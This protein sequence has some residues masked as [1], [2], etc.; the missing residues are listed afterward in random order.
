M[1][2]VPTLFFLN[3]KLSFVVKLFG[4]IEV[5]IIRPSLDPSSCFILI[6]DET[7]NMKD[8]RNHI[9]YTATHEF[10]S[11]T[12]TFKSYFAIINI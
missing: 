9:L 11:K 8:L 4:N 5:S 12:K 7:E 1:T 2:G 10:L 3:I 6:L